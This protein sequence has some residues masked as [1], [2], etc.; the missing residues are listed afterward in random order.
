MASVMPSA[1]S[2]LTNH[3]APSAGVVPAGSSM[4]SRTFMVRYCEY[5]AP[6][7]IETFLP[8]SALAASEDPVLIT[9]PAP[10]LPTGNDWA[11]RAAII[12]S[13]A[14]G[15]FAVTTGVSGLPETLAV[16]MSA[17]P[18][19]SPRSDGLIGVAS[20]RTTTSSSAGSGVGTSTSDSSSSPLFLSSE[21]SCSPLL[22]SLMVRP[23]PFVLVISGGAG[24][25]RQCLQR[26]FAGIFRLLAELLLDAQELVVLGGAVG[27][28]QRAGFDLAA[29]G[30]DREVG[31]GGVFGLAG[32]VR[33]HGG[34]AVLVGQF[35]GGERFRQI[36]R[37]SCRER[38]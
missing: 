12:R 5:I 31:D 24:A 7:I 37:A 2:G 4:T 29:I 34:I 18:I 32:T 30:G 1:V 14:S 25:L 35:D 15:I 19:R 27:A 13:A 36:G 10:S 23:P 22:S 11:S 28:C 26:R 21:R 33:H 38:V 6:P 3:D 8:I 9:T 17:G 20:T 16:D